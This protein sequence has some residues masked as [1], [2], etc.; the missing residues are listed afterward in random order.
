MVIN[1]ATES[2]GM[3]VQANNNQQWLSMGASLFCDAYCPTD[4]PK[5]M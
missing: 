5:H 4:I 3:K 2:A 1:L